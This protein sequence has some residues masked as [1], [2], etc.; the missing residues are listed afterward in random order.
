[1]CTY[2]TCHAI[3]HMPQLCLSIW[4]LRGA[5]F[6]RHIIPCIEIL[7]RSYK[8]NLLLLISFLL[9][10][11][12]SC[13]CLRP[14][15]TGHNLTSTGYGAGWGWG[16]MPEINQEY[17]ISGKSLLLEITY[18]E[19]SFVLNGTGYYYVLSYLTRTY[20]MSIKQV[21]DT[22]SARDYR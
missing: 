11:K 17:A 20:S 16:S 22:I 4:W 14:Q 10:R 21:S 7:S 12:N 13:L 18:D 5:A 19:S 6:S 1:M 9:F 2:F 15:G 3:C 8:Y